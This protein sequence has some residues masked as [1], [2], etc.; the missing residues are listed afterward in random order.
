MFIVSFNLLSFHAFAQTSYQKLLDTAVTT[1]NSIFVDSKPLKTIRLD[2][3]NMW[4]YYNE[5]IEDLKII[6]DT[7]MFV[8]IVKNSKSVDESEWTDKNS[9]TDPRGQR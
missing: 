7:I 6:L 3:A 4:D 5:Y 2:R 9:K 1:K 8:Q